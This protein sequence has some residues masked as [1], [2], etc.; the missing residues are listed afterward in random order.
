MYL[1]FF[2]SF[3]GTNILTS[4]NPFF[5]LFSEGFPNYKA[6]G[7]NVKFARLSFDSRYQSNALKMECF[8][9]IFLFIYT[10]L[11]HKKKMYIFRTVHPYLFL[12]PFRGFIIFHL[13]QTIG[14]L[15]LRGNL[16]E[17]CVSTSV[18]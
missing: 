8:S 10:T 16:S 3:S 14:E 1:P 15:R 12:V 9:S 7:R 2:H 5:I 4:S 13:F 6:F 17:L 18:V 11:V